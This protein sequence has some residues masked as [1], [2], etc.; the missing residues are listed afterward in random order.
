MGDHPRASSHDHSD[1]IGFYEKHAPSSGGEGVDGRKHIVQIDN[2][3]AR[4]CVNIIYNN[5]NNNNN[6][7]RICIII[8]D[9]FTGSRAR[10]L[11]R[12]SVS[13]SPIF[14]RCRYARAVPLSPYRR[15]Y[16]RGG[17]FFSRVSTVFVRTPLARRW[18]LT[19]RCPA[20]QSTLDR[21]QQCADNWTEWYTM[22][23]TISY[24]DIL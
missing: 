7:L 2:A 8:N 17:G 3:R 16:P 1:K 11:N 20:P 13:V 12:P 21:H 5:N 4:V 23:T 14:T 24:Y 22:C 19:A 18:T 9:I 10:P 6:I 15:D